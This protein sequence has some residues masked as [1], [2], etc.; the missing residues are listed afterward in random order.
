MHERI[1]GS[2]NNMDVRS[3]VL[4]IVPEGIPTRCCSWMVV[5]QKRDGTPRPTVDLQSLNR[6]CLKDTHHTQAPFHLLNQ[7][8]PNSYKAL[9]DAKDGYHVVK[10]DEESRDLITF[11][12]EWAHNHYTRGP[13]GFTGTG[14]LYTRR[15]HDITMEFQNKVKIVDDTLLFANSMEEAFW[16]TFNFLYHSSSLGMT[17]NPA[18]FKFAHTDIDFVGFRGTQVLPPDMTYSIIS[19]PYKSI[20]LGYGHGTAS[21]IR[22]QGLTNYNLIWSLLDNYSVARG[23]ATRVT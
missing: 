5:V 13:Q 14:D 15:T 2:S 8:P 22:C 18:K 7:I 10:L 9:L 23:V 20:S 21:S 1:E 3:G 17:F 16:D 4:E 12:T 6:E 19:P 11:I